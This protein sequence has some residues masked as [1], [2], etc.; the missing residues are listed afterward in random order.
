MSKKTVKTVLRK[1]NLY[2]ENLGKIDYHMNILNSDAKRLISKI[3]GEGIF[4]DVEKLSE[5]EKAKL[6]LKL[7]KK[8]DANSEEYDEDLD[9]EMTRFGL[10]LNDNIS[11]GKTPSK[12]NNGG[13][14]EDDGFGFGTEPTSIYDD[15]MDSESGFSR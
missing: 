11:I 13:M 15:Y 9:K 14:F 4:A 2:D 3:S 10:E 6:L 8:C 12:W 1:N 5:L 7:I